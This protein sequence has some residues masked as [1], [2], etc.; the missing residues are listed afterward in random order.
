M[1][2]A[3]TAQLGEQN[4]TDVQAAQPPAH[5]QTW[6]PR[7]YENAV[8]KGRIE[9]AE[10]AGSQAAGCAS[11][12]Q[13][14][15]RLIS[16][17]LPRSWRLT[18]GLEVRAVM[19]KGRRVRARELEF[20]WRPNDL[21]HPR[22]GLVVPRHNAT[23]VARNRL[24]RRLREILRRRIVTRMPPVDLVLKTRAHAYQS[25]FGELASDLD[26]WLVSVSE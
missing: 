16:E 14:R 18:S 6:I 20:F 15:A 7:P 26:Q 5:Q 9:S 17:E 21:G 24:R 22:V 4:E 13:A 25:R 12:V 11:A 23:A 2:L 1:P 10:E 19:R 3:Y 8:G